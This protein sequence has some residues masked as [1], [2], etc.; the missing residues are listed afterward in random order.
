[1]FHKAGVLVSIGY[2]D[3]IG[4]VF[5]QPIFREDVLAP[6]S[7]EDVDQNDVP[8]DEDDG[9]D[10]DS[11]DEDHECQEKKGV[12]KG[13]LIAEVINGQGT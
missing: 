12:E 2:E 8:L 13:L 9:A 11:D 5:V 7:G 6:G 10:S 1:M 4:L 3:I